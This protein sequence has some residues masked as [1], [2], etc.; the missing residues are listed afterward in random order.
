M[1]LPHLILF[2]LLLLPLMGFGEAVWAQ[3]V[4]SSLYGLPV[5]EINIVGLK[6]TKEHIIRRDLVSKVGKPY[7][8]ETANLDRAHLDRLRIFSDIQFHPYR[9]GDEVV[10]GIALKETFPMLPTV[11]FDV[12]EENG[13]SLGAGVEHINLFGRAIYGNAIFMLGGL[14]TIGLALNDPWVLGNHFSYDAQ[15]FFNTRDN[16]VVGFRETAH[17]FNAVLMGWIRE[18]GRLGGRLQFFSIESDTTG[19]TLSP[20]NRD[21][22]PILGFGGGLDSRDQVV[23][24]QRGIWSFVEVQKHGLFGWGDADF[25]QYIID[26]GFYLPIRPRHTIHLASLLELRTG[27]VGKEVAPWQVFSLGGANTVR[28]FPLNSRVGKNE[29]IN[30]AEYRFTVMEQRPVTLLFNLQWTFGVHLAAFVDAGHAWSTKEEF[31]FAA[32]GKLFPDFIV[33]YGL[34]ARLLTPFGLIRLDF[35][36]GA[37]NLGIAFHFGTREK[38]ERQRSRIR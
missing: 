7:T 19:A 33:G 36:L 27:E 12:T 35:G 9:D 18:T 21:I 14:N 4:D 25:W 38:V 2:G 8:E 32:D 16:N 37:E 6:R 22:V 15:Y 26:L 34:G 30:T 1:R 10:L 11:I 24:A 31:T 20:T 28:G 3:Q 17:E 13:V 23:N 29:M 5:K